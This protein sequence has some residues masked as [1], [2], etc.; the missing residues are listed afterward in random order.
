[1]FSFL[2]V[3][4]FKDLYVFQGISDAGLR[5]MV[6]ELSSYLAAHL[7]EQ[8]GNGTFRQLFLQR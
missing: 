8:Y 7:T 5:N 1:M 2:L 6:A 3:F 4:S